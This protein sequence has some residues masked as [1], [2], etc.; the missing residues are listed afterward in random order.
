MKMLPS[1]IK[2]LI[3]DYNNG[4]TQE[5]LAKKYKM[6]RTS[7]ISLKNKLV[8]QGLLKFRG[9]PRRKRAS[10]PQIAKDLASIHS[11]SWSPKKSRKG[12][13]KIHSSGK[14]EIVVADAHNPYVDSDTFDILL[15]VLETID[16]DIFVD[17]GDTCNFTSLSPFARSAGDLDTLLEYTLEQENI[18]TN[19]YF[20]LIDERLPKNCE[21]HWFDSNHTAWAQ[22]F[23]DKNPNLNSL[24]FHPRESWKLDERGYI[25]HERRAIDKI[26]NL[27]HCHGDIIHTRAS[28]IAAKLLKEYI[29]D[30]FIAGHFHVHQ[31]VLIPTSYQKPPLE[32]ILIPALSVV[33]MKYIRNKPSSVLNGF[34][35]VFHS[36]S[37]A[38]FVT[39]HKVINGEAWVYG[40]LYKSRIRGKK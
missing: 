4:L 28:T 38:F 33:N 30:S 24:P 23:L 27:A 1:E 2:S 10:V 16:F 3:E 12:K 40:T 36:K 37:G 18:L 11:K 29:H 17:L 8:L 22:Q 13:K 5:E 26:A 39:V 20:D 6:G 31:H 34:A 21:K 15:Q 9:H 14:L 25:I 32:G 7:V 19:Q 35:T